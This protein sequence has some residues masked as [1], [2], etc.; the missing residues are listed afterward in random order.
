MHL[1]KNTLASSGRLLPG[2]PKA[3]LGT[4]LLFGVGSFALAQNLVVR[5]TGPSPRRTAAG[6]HMGNDV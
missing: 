1:D 5:P 2:F 4:F 3:A 6:P